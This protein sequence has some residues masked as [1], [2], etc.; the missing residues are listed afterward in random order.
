M[1]SPPE[2][3]DG[4]ELLAGARIVPVAGRTLGNADN[5]VPQRYIWDFEGDTPGFGVTDTKAEAIAAALQAYITHHRT[6]KP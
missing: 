5:G 3:E 6:I 1:P 2:S 4:D